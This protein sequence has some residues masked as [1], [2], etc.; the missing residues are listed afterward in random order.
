MR[1]WSQHG[2]FLHK[3]RSWTAINAPPWHLQHQTSHQMICIPTLCM[4]TPHTC[5]KQFHP[6][7]PMPP[8]PS[9]HAY[10]CICGSMHIYA[11]TCIYLHAFMYVDLQVVACKYKYIHP[12]GCVCRCV[13]AGARQLCRG[14]GHGQRS[15]HPHGISSITRHIKIQFASPRYA[16]P[17]HTPP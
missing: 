6:A 3:A 16:C 7:A 12:C 11:H 15:T 9:L 8:T 1:R 14:N 2:R 5:M 13:Q 4:P 17:P 10:I